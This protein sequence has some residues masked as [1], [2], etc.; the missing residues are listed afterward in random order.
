MTIGGLGKGLLDFAG[1]YREG[2]PELDGHVEARWK[3][4]PG[5]LLARGGTGSSMKFEAGSLGGKSAADCTSRSKD[6]GCE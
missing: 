4:D 3:I 1:R 2:L 5:P 6:A